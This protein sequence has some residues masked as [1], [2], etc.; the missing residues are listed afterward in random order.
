MFVCRLITTFTPDYCFSPV[1][2]VSEDTTLTEV[3]IFGTKLVHNMCLTTVTAKPSKNPDQKLCLQ[4]AGTVTCLGT[5]VSGA[6]CKVQEERVYA[7]EMVRTGHVHCK[8]RGAD[9]QE[10]T[11]IRR[12][13]KPETSKVTKL[14]G[15]GAGAMTGTMAIVFVVYIVISKVRAPKGSPTAFL[16]D[17]YDEASPTLQPSTSGPSPPRSRV[18]RHSRVSPEVDPLPGPSVALPRPRTPR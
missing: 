16:D 3:H 1:A 11:I 10:V 12:N 7:R 14:A 15:F 2:T 5:S 18:R 8:C 4:V 9:N 17:S 13:P 6:N